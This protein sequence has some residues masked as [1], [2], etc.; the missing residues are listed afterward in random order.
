[1]QPLNAKLAVPIGHLLALPLTDKDRSKIA[2]LAITTFT[3]VVIGIYVDSWNVFERTIFER[4]KTDASC[5]APVE[6][7]KGPIGDAE[8][9][10]IAN[11]R[12][13][14]SASQLTQTRKRTSPVSAQALLEHSQALLKRW[15]F[16]SLRGEK[17]R[18]NHQQQVFQ[19]GTCGLIERSAI[20]DTSG[21]DTQ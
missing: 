18:E 15:K 7:C 11:C 21:L 20:F 3:H 5:K 19:I 1:M 17:R 16:T 6:D 8:S 4:V 2:E 12:L 9:C 10:K 14:L 13:A